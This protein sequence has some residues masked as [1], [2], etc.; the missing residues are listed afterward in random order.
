MMQIVHYPNLRSFMKRHKLTIE[1]ISKIL[2]KSYPSVHKKIN[3]KA[4]ENGK[5][6]LFDIEEARTL[7]KFVIST[8]QEYLK[9]KY[10]DRW[11]EE[12][13]IRWGH[14]NDWLAYIF[15]DEV[16]INVTKTA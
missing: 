10:G 4:T 9:G 3:R 12:W 8:E 5:V 15:F 1:D 6:A 13:N 7:I 11:E 14:I 16:V 2:K